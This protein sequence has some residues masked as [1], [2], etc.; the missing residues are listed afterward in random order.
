M[1]CWILSDYF[2]DDGS[3]ACA[4]FKDSDI[5]CPSGDVFPRGKNGFYFT[6]YSCQLQ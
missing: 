1:H 2:N 4:L 5:W 6:I 3:I